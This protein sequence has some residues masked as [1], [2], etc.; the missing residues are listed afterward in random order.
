INGQGD[1]VL[2][3]NNVIDS[4]N[5]K[6]LNLQTI[7]GTASPT[8]TLGIGANLPAGDLTGATEQVNGLLF[9]SLGNSH[10]LRLI[11]TNTRANTCSMSLQAPA[12]HAVATQKTQKGEIYHPQGRIYLDP[13]ATGAVVGTIN[14]SA[15]GQ[16]FEIVLDPNNPDTTGPYD[17][18]QSPLTVGTNG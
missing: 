3:N 6:P 11:Y 4:T 5:V 12:D 16:S 13:N 8:T 15:N 9:D 10:N 18:T 7:G 14:M 2:I 17:I 1:Q